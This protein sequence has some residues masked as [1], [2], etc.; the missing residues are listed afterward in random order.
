[1]KKKTLKIMKI[2]IF[3]ILIL[4]TKKMKKKIKN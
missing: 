1:M 4:K 3:Q 2:K